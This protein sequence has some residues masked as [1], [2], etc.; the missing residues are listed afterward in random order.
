MRTS[1]QEQGRLV[2]RRTVLAGAALLLAVGGCATTDIGDPDTWPVIDL[3]PGDPNI[4]IP[5]ADIGRRTRVVV[6]E[7]EESAGNRGQGLA[8]VAT[9]AI[10]TVL[11]S[12][13]VEIIDRSLATR[14]GQEL[15]LAEMGGGTASYGGPDI[16]DFAIRVVM[17]NAGFGSVFHEAS[18][19]KDKKGQ[20]V[21]VPASYTYSARS[22][23]TV[24]IYQLPSL[25][26]VQSVNAE[27]TA[28][29]SDQRR[30]MNQN[31]GPPLMASA[32]QAGIRAKKADVL[33][34]FSPK[35]YVEQ[36]RGKEKKT[37][38]KVLLGKQTGSKTG[39]A[40]E[41]YTQRK[42]ESLLTKKV[43]YDEVLVAK[44]RISNSLQSDSSWVIVDDPKEA[45]R[46]RFGDIVKVK[47]STSFFDALNL[48]GLLQ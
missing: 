27:G 18:Q 4:K 11:G 6:L 36:R 29:A 16:A 45:A 41:I 3:A 33:N 9:A 47:H 7:P 14:L 25:R 46:V 22:S 42:N 28:S 5:V 17:G 24:R 44:G 32:T 21:Y 20:T 10:Q 37:I 1:D 19:Y 15:K 34:E 48:P 38:F 23:L 31:D 8:T 2:N 30:E 39:D 35:G 43:T 13:G 12:G 40:V 26:L